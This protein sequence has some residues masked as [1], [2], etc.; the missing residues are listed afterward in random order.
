MHLSSILKPLSHLSACNFGSLW[1]TGE[2][3]IS[4]NSFDIFSI[5]EKKGQLIQWEYLLNQLHQYIF[6]LSEPKHILELSVALLNWLPE[7]A[8]MS[9]EKEIEANILIDILPSFS[10]LAVSIPMMRVFVL[11]WDMWSNL[12]STRALLHIAMIYFTK[13]VNKVTN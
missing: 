12:K 7:Y 9:I 11:F 5:S 8:Y 6:F 4:L 2:I 13:V 10:C 3:K 1:Q